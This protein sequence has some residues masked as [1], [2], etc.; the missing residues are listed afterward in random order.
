[1]TT[2]KIHIDEELIREIADEMDLRDPNRDALTTLAGH[3]AVWQD[4]AQ[5]GTP[6]FVLDLATGVGKTYLLVAAISYLTRL[7]VRNFA[8]FVPRTAI[9]TKTLSNLQPG[10]PKSIVDSLPFPVRVITTDDLD[11]PATVAAMDDPDE[12]KVYVVTVQSLTGRDSDTKRKAHDFREELGTAFYESL[13]QIDDLIV[14]AD[15][16]HAYYGQSFSKAVRDLEPMCLVG[17]TATPDS[18]TPTEQIIYRYPLANAIEDR[19]VKRPVIVGRGDELADDRTK[20]YDGV[21]LLR[22]KQ[23][24]ADRYAERTGGAS[25]RN[26]LMLVVAEDIGE[27]ARIE[28]LLQAPDFFDGAYDGRVLRV[29]SSQPEEALA[30]L[31]DIED[32]DSPYRIVVSVAMLKEGW[33]VATV[34]VICSLRPSVSDLLTEQ[35]LGR[36]LRLPWGRWVDDQLLNELDVVAHASYEKVLAQARVLNEQRVD[37]RTWQAERHQALARQ[38]ADAATAEAAAHIHDELAKLTHST[39]QRPG[40]SSGPTEAGAPGEHPATSGDGG[41]GGTP[42]DAPEWVQDFRL[43][44]DRIEEVT[45]TP[46]EHTLHPRLALGQVA[47]PVMEVVEQT[48]GDYELSD[49]LAHA[50]TAFAELGARFARDPE[51]ELRRTAVVAKTERGKDGIAVTRVMTVPADTRITSDAEPPPLD[52]VRSHLIEAILSS[53]YAT[54]TLLERNSAE[55]IV[56]SLIGG[57]ADK[58]A[59]LGAYLDQVTGALLRT[60]GRVVG[61]LAPKMRRT[62]IIEHREITWQRARADSTSEDRLGEFE[63]GVGYIGWRKHL[64]EQA[65]F[66]SKPERDVAV[67]ADGSD[68]VEFFVRLHNNDLPVAWTG[69]GKVRDYNPDLLVVEHAHDTPTGRVRRCWLVEVKSDKDD[70]ADDVKAKHAAAARWAARANAQRTGDR[71]NVLRVNETDVRNAKGSWSALKQLGRTAF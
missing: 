51:G 41:T 38:A 63:K 43:I 47:V 15:E 1:M 16:H 2:P 17:L 3:L 12:V 21:V 36:G 65:R 69:D 46:D 68:D 8:V 33:D 24:A 18:K 62:E 70:E 40:T 44:G 61:E 28:A 53:N 56:D 29:D 34:A 27:A 11:T 19:H 42:P 64:Y 59:S 57:A 67:A 45:T 35:T 20:L 52:E 39:V 31:A 60:L 55:E 7:G 9:L 5:Q 66:D 71:W 23:Q 6:E 48:V 25:G 58:A 30:A 26:L 50:P 22:A 37:W 49:V 54:G 14:F 4:S 13:R 10:H 32:A